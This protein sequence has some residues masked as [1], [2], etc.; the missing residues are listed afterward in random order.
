MIFNVVYTPGTTHLAFLATSL[1]RWSEISLRLVANHCPEDEQRYLREICRRDSRLEY[2]A[3][4][5]AGRMVHHEIALNHLQALTTGDKFCFLDSDIFAAGAFLAHFRRLWDDHAGVFAG[6]PVWCLAEEQVLPPDGVIMAGE[7][8]RA[9]DGRCLGGTYFAIY[10]NRALTGFRR[11]HGFLFERG[12]WRHLAAQRQHQL[13]TL[14]LRQDFYDTGKLLNIFLTEQGRPL[15]FSETDTLHHL[16]GVSYVPLKRTR[17]AEDRAQKV[18]AL[19]RAPWRAAPLLYRRT[20]RAVQRSLRPGVFDKAGKLSFSVRRDLYS[21]YFSDVLAALHAGTPLP[22]LPVCGV[23]AIEQR[24]AATTKQLA[25]LH[26]EFAGEVARV[27]GAPCDVKAA[28]AA[29]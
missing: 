5:D 18:T 24:I 28:P 15:I 16:G 9:A 3:L 13:E 11:A 25:A 8:H 20:R 14:G 10:D 19:W 17:A 12:Y 26:Q 7:Y 22:P 27:S 6:A 23:T 21:F 29:Y 4:P 1:L 2:Y